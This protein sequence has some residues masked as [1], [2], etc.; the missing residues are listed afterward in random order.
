MSN[1]FCIVDPEIVSGVPVFAGT[2]VPVK[3]LFD[4]IAEGDTVDAFPVWF[5]W[6]Y[7]GAVTTVFNPS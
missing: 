1:D 4:Y 3:A 7:T 6:R 5:P 2:R